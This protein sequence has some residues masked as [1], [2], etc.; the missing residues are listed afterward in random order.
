MLR[1]PR[2]TG[3]DYRRVRHVQSRCRATGWPACWRALM[4]A[5]NASPSSLLAGYDS[6]FSSGNRSM[7]DSPSSGSS[8]SCSRALESCVTRPSSTRSVFTLLND[9]NSSCHCVLSASRSHSDD[10]ECLQ[11]SRVR[12]PTAVEAFAFNRDFEGTLLC[13]CMGIYTHSNTPG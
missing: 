6:S 12:P 11:Y 7:G 9:L 1:S 2:S 10:S 4:K 13:P 8:S 5:V 3:Y